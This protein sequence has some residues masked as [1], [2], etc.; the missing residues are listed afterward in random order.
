[1]GEVG[2]KEGLKR[3]G[4]VLIRSGWVLIRSGWVLRRAGLVEEDWV[5]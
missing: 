4:W 5:G 2:K 1:M 3:S